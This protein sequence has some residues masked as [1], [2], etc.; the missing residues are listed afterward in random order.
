MGNAGMDDEQRNRQIM[1]NEEKRQTVGAIRVSTWAIALT[2][3]AGAIAVGLGWAW[4][5]R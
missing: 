5:K 2:I 3:I 4:L 1:R